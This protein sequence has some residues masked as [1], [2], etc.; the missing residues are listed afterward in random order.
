MPEQTDPALDLPWP[1]GQ[2]LLQD[3]AGA[4][5][6]A[7]S[8]TLWHIGQSGFVVRGGECTLVFDPY[9]HRSERRT[10]PPPFNGEELHDVDFVFCSHDHGDHL[11]PVA[12]KGLRSGSPEARFVVSRAAQEKMQS[13]GVS[14]ERLVIAPRSEERV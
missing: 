14:G 12:V 7:G 4:V 5:T 13:L 9:L 11:D 1:H 10:F 2:S 3:I 8:L 6:P